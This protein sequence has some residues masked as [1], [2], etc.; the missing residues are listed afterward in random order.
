MK[1]R[2]TGNGH[3]INIPIP[4]RLIFSKASVKIYLK[5][6]RTFSSTGSRYLPDHVEK[7]AEKWLDK[8]PDEAILALC[9]EIVRI[10]KKHGQWNLVEVHTADGEHVEITL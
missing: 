2:V 6:A 3:N 4:T 5:L 1:I 7:K 8:I 9:A 10:K